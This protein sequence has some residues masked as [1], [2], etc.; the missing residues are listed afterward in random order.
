MPATCLASLIVNRTKNANFLKI[1]S[2]HT[3]HHALSPKKQ[4][5]SVINTTDPGEKGKRKYP[6]AQG[7]WHSTAGENIRSIFKMIIKI[8]AQC[9]EIGLFED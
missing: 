1:F 8:K 5:V 9:E 7:H 6:T 2:I 4:A 3:N